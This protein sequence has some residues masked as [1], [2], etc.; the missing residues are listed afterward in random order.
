MRIIEVLF[1]VCE[2]RKQK[3]GP[4]YLRY[5][6]SYIVSG[7]IGRGGLFFGGATQSGPTDQVGGG[8]EFITGF[9]PFFFSFT[10][11]ISCPPPERERERD[12]N[13][14][15]TFDPALSCYDHYDESR[16]RLESERERM[17]QVIYAV[18]ATRHTSN[19]ERG[20]TP[21]FLMIS[22]SPIFIFIVSHI[23]LLMYVSYELWK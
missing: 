9:P 6:F 1:S 23:A 14:N 11:G 20:D 19:E 16:W 17:S 21:S 7:G 22:P 2:R 8:G 13:E 4:V 15:I 3:G 5:E 18:A 12:G 10:C